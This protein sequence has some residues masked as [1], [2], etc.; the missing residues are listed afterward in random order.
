MDKNISREKI[1]RSNQAIDSIDLVPIDSKVVGILYYL[2]KRSFDDDDGFF[3]WSHCSAGRTS[4]SNAK[5]K[6]DSKGDWPAYRSDIT[7]D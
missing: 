6:A 2:C 5:A 3:I 1:W 7:N 4:D